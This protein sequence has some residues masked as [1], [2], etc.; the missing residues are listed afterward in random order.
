MESKIPQIVLGGVAAYAVY[1]QLLKFRS[2]R[3]TPRNY[4]SLDEI[5][6][7]IDLVASKLAMDKEDVI[8]ALPHLRY[9]SNQLV[10]P[11]NGRGISRWIDHTLL[12]PNATYIEIQKLCEEAHQNNFYAVCV[13]PSRVEFACSV[14]KSLRKP[15]DKNEVKVA[16]VVGFP[17]GATTTQSKTYEA[18][19]AVE[20]G[21]NEVD[22]VINI[23]KLLEG[24]YASVVQD[25]KGV[26]QVT[27]NKAIVK[28]IL[29]TS[30]LSKVQIIDSCILSV[31]GGAVFVKTSTGFGGGGAT[32]EDVSI[33]K[34]VV[35]NQA[36][37]K[38]SGGVR[39]FEE[40]AKLIKVGAGRIGTSAG[41]A[42][43]TG[44]E[45]DH[46]Y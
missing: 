45:V 22:M 37:V 12:K 23:G 43:V 5:M 21:A 35:G 15:N 13:N 20:L 4:A 7:R 2:N 19:E 28:V 44:E 42:I 33:M 17:L 6:K 1:Y 27:A 38:A 30:M 10:P 29:E 8:N 31:L 40:A 36:M 11:W 18:K 32:V 24:D 39:S 26:V 34:S 41:I 9:N 46:G 25:I 16:A 14:L 3:L